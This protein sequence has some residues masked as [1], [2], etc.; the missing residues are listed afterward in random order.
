M[1]R[2]VKFQGLLPSVR[3]GNGEWRALESRD[4]E[5][6]RAFVER[7][8]CDEGYDIVVE[9]TTPGDDRAKAREEVRNWKD[10]GATWWMESMWEIQDQPRRRELFDERVKQGPPA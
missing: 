5:Q 2:V 8:G 3:D 4:V 7:Q 9:G 10:A 6:M 1:S